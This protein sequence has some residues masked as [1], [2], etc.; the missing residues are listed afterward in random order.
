MCRLTAQ[1]EPWEG[2]VKRKLTGT[3]QGKMFWENYF[4]EKELEQNGSEN[5]HL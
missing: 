5:T 1:C 2:G 3:V 4:S